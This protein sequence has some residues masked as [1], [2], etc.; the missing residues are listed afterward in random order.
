MPTQFLFP[1]L[2]SFYSFLTLFILSSNTK[3][4][5]CPMAFSNLF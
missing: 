3:L 1:N 4:D 2:L 5:T